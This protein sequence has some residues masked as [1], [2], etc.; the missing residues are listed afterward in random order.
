M[1]SISRQVPQIGGLEEQVYALYRQRAQKMVQRRRQDVRDQNDEFSPF[2]GKGALGDE[3]RTRRA[4]EREGRRTRRRR[5][6]EK[7]GD[8]NHHD[9]M[10]TDDEESQSEI[11]LMQSELG[12]CVCVFS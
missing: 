11:Q 5:E 6:R 4:A 3:Y 2:A 1:E 7:R 10:S 9:G 12:V 8:S